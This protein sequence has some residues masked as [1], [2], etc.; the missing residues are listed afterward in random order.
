MSGQ[1][2]AGKSTLVRALAGELAFEELPEREK[3]N[4]YL[5]RYYQDPKSW[6]FKSFLFFFEQSVSD[7][8]RARQHTRGAL[9]ERSPYEHLQVFGRE[10]HAKSFLSDDDLALFERL[11]VTAMH[12]ATTP[13]LLIHLEVDAATARSR[14]RRRDRVAERA[15]SLDYLCALERR[16]QQF[17]DAWDLCPVLRLDTVKVDLRTATAVRSVAEQV[18]QALSPEGP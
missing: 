8:L 6:A 14:V 18:L 17:V 3:E 13:D 12:G 2:G 7:Y 4:P 16:Y 1:I 11:M 10:F 5:E 9:Q 15:V